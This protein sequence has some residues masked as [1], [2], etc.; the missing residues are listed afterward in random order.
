MPFTPIFIGGDA[1][2]LM[3]M[4]NEDSES[5]KSALQESDEARESVNDP[6][7]IDAVDA[8]RDKDE[9]GPAPAKEGEDVQRASIIE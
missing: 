9:D 6:I 7:V 3:P 5:L 2:F 4:N 8:D 1:Y